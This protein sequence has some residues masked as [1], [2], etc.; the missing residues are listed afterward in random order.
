MKLSILSTV[1]LSTAVA[2]LT[3]P[4]N[5]G[6]GCGQYPVSGLGARKQQI[7]SA[8]GTAKDLAIA[9]METENMGTNYV[10]GD[11]KSDDA[12]NFGIFK[13]N[14]GMLRASCSQFQG[15]STAD[16]NNG[17]VLNSNLEQDIQCRHESESFYGFQTWVA[18]H[19]NGESG[20]A[21][22]NTSDIALYM[23][24]IEWTQQQLEG[25]SYLTDDTRF[26]VDV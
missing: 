12:A 19:R 3:C 21:D 22:P 14:W 17:A 13:Q 18:G 7:Q 1:A 11:N 25:G 20:L 24:A 10:Y 8:G 6:G 2:G 16:Y 4:T 15:Q 26:W 5:S 23:S 9:M